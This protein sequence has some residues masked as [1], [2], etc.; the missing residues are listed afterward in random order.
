MESY[1]FADKMKGI[2]ELNLSCG[3]CVV[4]MIFN[5]IVEIYQARPPRNPKCAV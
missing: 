1:C 5:Y 4:G 3:V 2:L